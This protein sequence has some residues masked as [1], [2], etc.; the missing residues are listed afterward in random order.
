MTDRLRGLLAHTRTAVILATTGLVLFILAYATQSRLL[1]S[2]S[3]VFS[4]TELERSDLSIHR[5]APYP[6]PAYPGMHLNSETH[7]T[8]NPRMRE[9]QSQTVTI[10]YSVKPPP[11]YSSPTPLGDIAVPSLS[12][13]LASDDFA[14]TPSETHR[15]TG[16]DNLPFQFPFMW[17]ISPKSEGDYALYVDFS[18]L[19][20][21]PDRGSTVESF[22]INGK[23]EA[24]S[25]WRKLIIPIT[26]TTHLDLSRKT[27]SLILYGAQ[28]VAFMLTCPLIVVVIGALWKWIRT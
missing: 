3:V 11:G 28:V 23:T 20:W 2:G 19:E 18:G 26:V 7:L 5:T 1:H 12:V 22:T 6:I 13:T 14:I 21:E 8:Y 15:T 27:V 9:N 4:D 10:R 24:L 25:E 17:L 16:N